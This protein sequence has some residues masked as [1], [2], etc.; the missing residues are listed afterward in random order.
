MTNKLSAGMGDLRRAAVPDPPDREPLIFGR[1][2]AD[3]RRAVQELAH[4]R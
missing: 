2:D 4:A 3:S 1:E